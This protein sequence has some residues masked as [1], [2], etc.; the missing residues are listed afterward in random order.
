MDTLTRLIQSPEYTELRPAADL[1]ID[2]RYQGT[3]NFIKQNL[4]GTFN[5]AFLHRHAFAAFDLARAELAK[6]A[7]SL[8]FVVYDALRPRSIQRILWQAVVGTPNQKYLADP[9]RGS[10]HNYGFAIDLGLTDRGGRELDMG[11]GFD[12]FREIAQ[13]QFEGRF[14]ASG[15]LTPAQIS[16][17]DLLRAVMAAGGWT[18][19]AHEWWH[20]DAKSR[21]DVEANYVIVE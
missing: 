3:N 4:Y 9:D 12:D 6:R 8:S 21:A 20:F 15:E 1:T 7:P 17:R 2:L 11:A 5:R 10:L 14:L 19:L 18:Q 16:N 13:P